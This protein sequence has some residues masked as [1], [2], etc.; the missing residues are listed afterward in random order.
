MTTCR[1]FKRRTVMWFFGAQHKETPM[2]AAPFYAAA[3]GVLSMKIP[4][5]ELG[6]NRLSGV[7]KHFERPRIAVDKQF[8]SVL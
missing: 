4:Y 7:K 3:S 2:R 8:V 5:P 1:A 6:K